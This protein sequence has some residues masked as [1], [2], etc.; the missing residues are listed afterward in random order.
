VGLVLRRLR[1]V[2]RL[3]FVRR[4]QWLFELRR[5]LELRWLQHVRVVVVWLVLRPVGLLRR[6]GRL[7]C[8][9]LRHVELRLWQLWVRLVLRT[10]LRAELRLRHIHERGLRCDD[11]SAK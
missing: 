8:R 7:R 1:L 3:Q 6:G 11:N 5:L 10:G 4:L 9:G 2:R